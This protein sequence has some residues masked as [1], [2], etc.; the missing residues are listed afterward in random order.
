MN[1]KNTG[2]TWG[3]SGLI[4][5][6]ASALF[7]GAALPS[8]GSTLLWLSLVLAAGAQAWRWQQASRATQAQVNALTQQLQRNEAE[9]QQQVAYADTILSKVH[10][11][12]VVVDHAGHIQDCNQ[13]LLKMTGFGRDA[14]MGQASSSLFEDDEAKTL[15][16]LKG[17]GQ[18][19]T[20]LGVEDPAGYAQFLDGSLL[21][22]LLMSQKGLVLKVNQRFAQLSGHAAN[23]L[24][25]QSVQDAF[26]GQ[27][28]QNLLHPSE[29]EPD[30]WTE[31]QNA[32]DTFYRS[33]AEPPLSLRCH[34][35]QMLSVEVSLINHL[36]LGEIVTLVLVRSAQD[37]PWGVANSTALQKLT[38]SDEDATV[39]QLRHHSG[40]HIP[41]RVSSSFIVDAS[42]IPLQTVINVTDV[43]SLVNKGEELRAQHQLLQ[44]TMDAMQDGVLRIDRTGQ[45]VSA[46]PMALDL[47][48]LG[49]TA[50]TGQSVHEL[51][52]GKQHG[53]DLAFWL[54]MSTELLLRCLAQNLQEKPE[55]VHS[56]PIP[57]LTTN[58]LGRL[59]WATP[60]ACA[61]LGLSNAPQLTSEALL[62]A[63]QTTRELLA[64]RSKSLGTDPVITD[65]SWRA[66]NA[67]VMRLP[68]MVIDSQTNP[69]EEMMVWLIPD[70]DAL[71][72]FMIRRAHNIDWTILQHADGRL[73]PVILTASP[74]EDPYNRLTGAVI[75]IKDMREIK[76]KESENLRMVQKMEQSQRLDAL[77]QLAA[78]VAHDFNNLLGVIQNH[79][80]LVEMKLGAETKVT[81]NLSAI[82]QATMRARDI[83]LK[84]NAL[85]RERKRLDEDGSVHDEQEVQTWFELK[86]LIEET[87]GLLLASLKGINIQAHMDAV[88]DKLLIKGQSGTLQQVVVNLC[89][90]GS[91]AIGDRRDGLISVTL[92]C[93]SEKL[94]RIVVGDNGSGIPAA[95]V[96][97]IF[98]PFFTT[99]EVG[100][101]TGLGLSMARSIITQMGGTIE[102]QTEEGKGS[103]FIIELP[104]SGNE[105][106]MPTQTH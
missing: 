35:G 40:A 94:V 77:G 36:H 65:V 32:D 8:W 98:E 89:V 3:W 85:G 60:T 20:R 44:M 83:V 7:W 69:S 92:S 76:E 21:G 31:W 93:P 34:D 46:N 102:C 67:P 97:R 28:I 45:V 51:L 1:S 9:L 104:C 14:L 48:G 71:S 49:D 29:H 16:I 25:G 91:H 106:Q 30:L 87:H 10:S 73:V 63:E 59:K 18:M 13:A 86:P 24:I 74:L 105:A 68:T 33:G 99:K 64:L 52:P 61:L 72:S 2:A 53:H 15:S 100:K 62:L 79:A 12:L 43:S 26:C 22:A 78:G 6:G 80:E 39:A 58:R 17:Y 38:P 57:L 90:N 27:P 82:Q 56:L 41:V 55:L 37:L 96:P 101:G 50:M 4:V 103:Q 66:G 70:L 84:L 5:V 11:G 47:L 19:L 81:K 42:G 54:P 88:P 95:I 75:T 23:A